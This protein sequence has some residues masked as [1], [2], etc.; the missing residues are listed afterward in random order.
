MEVA[1]AAEATKEEAATGEA[2]GATVGAMVEVLKASSPR[3]AT[4]CRSIRHL[5]AGIS[6]RKTLAVWAITAHSLTDSMSL[7][8]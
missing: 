2:T 3:L 8:R 7:G 4:T 6:R 1:V 5:Y